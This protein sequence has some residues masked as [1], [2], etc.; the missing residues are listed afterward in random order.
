M[1]LGEKETQQQRKKK[2]QKIKSA[3]CLTKGFSGLGTRPVQEF[4]WQTWSPGNLFLTAGKEF[5]R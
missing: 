1:A 2:E 5:S 3:G 4:L